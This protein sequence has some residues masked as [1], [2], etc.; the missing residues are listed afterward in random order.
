MENTITREFKKR[1]F[2]TGYNSFSFGDTGNSALSS[3]STSDHNVISTQQ[4][5]G[6]FQ[7]QVATSVEDLTRELT[8]HAEASGSIMGV[9][10]GGSAD[11]LRKT[12]FTLNQ[13]YIVARVQAETLIE[14]L[15]SN[16]LAL[17]SDA[18][19]LSAKDFVTR[20]GDMFLG[21]LH[22]GG[23]LMLIITVE[24]E[25]LES[26]STF[27]ASATAKAASANGKASFASALQSITQSQD[28]N[29]YVSHIGGK[30]PPED[31]EK[32]VDK[33]INYALDFESAAQSAP[34]IFE[35]VFFPYAN[36]PNAPA[37]L[38]TFIEAPAANLASLVQLKAQY[39]GAQ[40]AIQYAIDG[41]DA[42]GL[43]S[44]ELN[45]LKSWLSLAGQDINTI[46]KN[47]QHADVTQIP[48]ASQLTFHHAPDWYQSQ[49]NALGLEAASRLSFN[50]GFYLEWTADNSFLSSQQKGY[51][52]V[53]NK[54]QV[55]LKVVQGTG[56]IQ[57]GFKVNIETTED[58][59]AQT[60]RL[61]GSKNHL[62]LLYENTGFEADKQTWIIHKLDRS[63]PYVHYD[64]KVTLESVHWAGQQIKK[65]G[66]KEGGA[67]YL[68][69]DTPPKGQ[70]FTWKI[71]RPPPA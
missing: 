7:I 9:D 44:S 58:S 14:N 15:K 45:F 21:E 4:N 71:K 19:Q 51:P 23:S 48:N 2:G 38:A 59:M 29:I 63:D 69:T 64:D 6:V 50:S 31:V 36:V 5:S 43:A 37:G 42:F 11:F 1:D 57:D 62:D 26:K 8:A 60:P 27:D 61:A 13:T 39:L 10:V 32:D 49:V 56:P 25:D 55:V 52:T 65:R 40:A 18:A 34:S 68:T 70:S 67:F 28:I 30:P 54:P 41:S 33:A 20:Y 12:K 66:D 46:N 47:W 3:D 24:S 22:Y 53:A 16:N 35:A 17:S